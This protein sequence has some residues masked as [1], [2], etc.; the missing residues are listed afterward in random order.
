M[1][2]GD[3]PWASRGAATETE[4]PSAEVVGEPAAAP[5]ATAAAPVQKKRKK[6][7]YDDAVLHGLLEGQSESKLH[8][9]LQKKGVSA[10]RANQTIARA[11]AR[12]DS[13]REA[14]SEEVEEARGADRNRQLLIGAGLFAI[15]LF[16]TVAT[17][18]SATERGGGSYVLAW[19]PMV[20]GAIRVLRAL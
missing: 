11:R 5:D 20:Y 13:A 3:P 10:E 17:Y 12:I 8:A 9:W 2:E 14:E 19:G 15:G 16:L 4:A 6:K 7:R 18:S 1:S